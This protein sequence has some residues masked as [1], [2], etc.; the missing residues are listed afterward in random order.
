MIVMIL[1][2][3]DHGVRSR[4]LRG[5]KGRGRRGAIVEEGNPSRPSFNSFQPVIISLLAVLPLPE[6]LLLNRVD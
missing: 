4:D 1:R 6:F 5:K 3:R 2:S